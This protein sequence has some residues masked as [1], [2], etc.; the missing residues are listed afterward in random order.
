MNGILY[1]TSLNL[2]PAL[3][4]AYC[5]SCWQTESTCLSYYLR[6]RPLPIPFPWPRTLSA[7]FHRV[8][9]VDSIRSDPLSLSCWSLFIPLYYLIF[10]P[11]TNYY[12]KFYYMFAYFII[13]CSTSRIKT[14]WKQELSLFYSTLYV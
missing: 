2:S 1:L 13:F 8:F 9:S 3:L 10:I 5:P 6:Q 14:S 11:R 7:E 12:L 4:L